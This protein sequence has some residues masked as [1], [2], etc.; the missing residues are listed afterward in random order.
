MLKTKLFKYQEKGV[1]K[2]RRLDGRMLIGDEMGLGKTVQ[3]LA[4]CDE[5]DDARPII[6]VCPAA[7]K[8]NWQN[9][10]LKHI[11]MRSEVLESR[12]P[13]KRIPRN[14]A[15]MYIINYEILKYWKAW[16]RK[17]KPQ[18]IIIDECQRIKNRL[19]QVTKAC[20]SLCR[21][22]KRVIALS[23]TPMMNVPAELWPT[24]NIL[25]PDM[26]PDFFTFG[27]RYCGPK[28]QRWGWEFKGATKMDELH[29]ILKSEVMIRRRKRDVLHQLPKHS[30]HIQLI[31]LG[32]AQRK[33]YEFAK[34]D[35]IAWLKR[36]INDK[37]RIKKA[38]R[39]EAL[40]KLGY[41]SRII[42]QAKIPQTIEWIKTALDSSDGKFLI[43]TWHKSII[44]QLYEAFPKISV[45]MDGN[46]SSKNKQNAVDALTNNKSIRL[47]FCQLISG[48]IGWNG[49]AATTSIFVELG[50]RPA[51]H[52]Q[53]SARM[54]RIGQKRRSRSYWLI[55]KGTLDESKCAKLQRKQGT[56]DRVLDGA[57]Q[58][59]DMDIHDLL[60]Q[61]L[62]REV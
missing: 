15:P 10:A 60:I 22:V 26:F 4:Y 6:V 27:H 45:K 20:K 47:C 8:Y 29:S 13:P 52:S 54:D 57:K 42:A 21:K 41:L 32:K 59:N 30:N 50:D 2:L 48:G 3:A 16:L 58:G 5:L 39:A 28:K 37:R 12:T 36:N 24:L 62:L 17:L 61:E 51:D 23:G 7:L 38:A 33:E 46:T 31:Q 56:A 53:A 55:A 19:A 11:G 49:T 40:V 44:K 43:F 1:R 14:I 9:E 34:R 25:R 35:F 18:V